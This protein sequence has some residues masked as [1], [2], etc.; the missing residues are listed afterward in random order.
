MSNFA[1]RAPLSNLAVIFTAS[2]KCLKWTDDSYGSIKSFTDTP[3]SDDTSV[4]VPNFVESFLG[5]ILIGEVQKFG[6]RGTEKGPATRLYIGSDI[7]FSQR[8]LGY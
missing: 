7:I 3:S 4:I 2:S 8:S 1:R 5:M 6:R